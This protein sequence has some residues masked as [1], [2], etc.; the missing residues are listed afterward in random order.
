MS[1]RFTV[2]FDD[3]A[4]EVAMAGAN[5][6]PYLTRLQAKR[7]LEVTARMIARHLHSGEEVRISGFGTFGLKAC[8][9]RRWRNPLTGE[10]IDIPAH[11][12]IAFRPAAALKRLVEGKVR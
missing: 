5:G 10:V 4:S 9:G 7:L 2:S 11:E 6:V 12:V 1:T 8:T 3:L